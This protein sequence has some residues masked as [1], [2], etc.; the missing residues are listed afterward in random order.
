MFSGRNGMAEQPVSIHAN[1]AIPDLTF[2]LIAIRHFSLV[3]YVG[4]IRLL[5]F[6]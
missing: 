3:V 5:K 2:A 4:P 6:K 1:N